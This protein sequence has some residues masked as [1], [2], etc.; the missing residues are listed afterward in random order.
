MK[1]VFRSGL[2][3][4]IAGALLLGGCVKIQQQSKEIRVLPITFGTLER[5][6][7]EV[8]GNCEATGVVIKNKKGQLVGGYS[9]VGK[10]NDMNMSKDLG[11]SG[12]AKQTFW[13]ALMKKPQIVVRDAGAEAALHALLEKYPDID[14]FMNIRYE[15]TIVAT[16]SNTT[17]T[18]KATALGIELKTDR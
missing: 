4:V 16:G 5:T 10:V 7:Y 17:E 6:D 15:R 14:Y 13:E 2:I 1:K 9:K 11:V 3:P 12:T 8:V 18:V